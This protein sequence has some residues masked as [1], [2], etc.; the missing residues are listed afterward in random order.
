MRFP[1]KL[2]PSFE[3]QDR[4][5]WGQFFVFALT[6]LILSTT[7]P[8]IFTD[9]IN[10][11]PYRQG[12][13]ASHTVRA[14]RELLIEDTLGTERRR[15]DARQQA[16]RVFSRSTRESVAHQ[17]ETVFSALGGFS[18]EES[19]S[20]KRVYQERTT[21]ERRFNLDLVGEEWNVILTRSNWAPLESAVTEIA[22]P[23]LA[24]GI[25]A[26]KRPLRSMLTN[27]H[28]V[29][30][31]DAT[32]GSE[33]EINSTSELYDL[34][35][36]TDVA[37]ASFPAKGFRRGAAFDNVVRKLVESLLRPNV[38]YDVTETERRS[39]L[40]A[41]AVEP[42]YYRIKRGEVI[43]RA[44]DVISAS[45]ERRIQLLREEMQTS[46]DAWRHWAGYLILSS[47]ILLALHSFA[48]QCWPHYRPPL[49]DLVLLSVTLI[50][51]FLVMKLFWVLATSLSA[52]FYFFDPST[53]ILATPLAAGGILLQVTLGARGTFL[54]TLSFALL[55][56]VFLENSWL[57]LVLIVVGNIV[58]AL[59]VTTCTRRSAFIWAGARVAAVN[60]IIVLCFLL[61]FSD[62]SAAEKANRVLWA[63]VGGAFSGI[64]G[65]GLTPLAEHFGRYITDIKLLELASLDHPLLREL[66]VQAPGTWNHSMV[67]G[68]MAEA[69]AEA[70][71]ANPLL[72]RVGAYYHDVGKAKKP[73][74][75]V[76]NQT[77]ENRHD[78]LTPS[79]S[80][81]IIRT[82][83]KDGVEMAE[84]HGLPRPIIDFIPQH[85]GT[86]L[87]EYFYDKALSEA[88]EGEDVDESHYRYPGPK[89][90]T[91]EAGIL[92]LAD[93]VEASSRTLVDPSPA[94]I[95]GLVQKMINKVFTGGELD[96]SS[97]TLKDLH[98]IAKSFTRVL[99]GI[100]HRRIEYSEP[101]EKRRE[102]KGGGKTKN[103]APA[104]EATERAGQ[105]KHASRIVGEGEGEKRSGEGA[106]KK[107]DPTDSKETLKRL[108]I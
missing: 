16:K 47:T 64:L 93:G 107:Q 105:K 63:I 75:F 53:Y 43:V 18:A 48:L 106:A 9:L 49:R 27:G 86:A 78:K 74:Y 57:V 8:S 81:L 102:G 80:A 103:G 100:Y 35:E 66:S 82:H 46:D 68:Q 104:A 14:P 10:P 20:D 34:Q 56:G 26:N 52:M 11:V 67:M 42:V 21:F 91:R 17:L 79:M 37:A 61:L 25:V 2:V 77:R 4:T 108:G 94:K 98:L 62:F 7:L 95:Q 12:E 41:E 83:V 29:V 72:A 71:G 97:L 13:V 76:E 60:A 39:E 22:E 31:V 87:I 65:A 96:E 44:G 89:P 92:M 90:Q 15:T 36:V 84:K 19:D 85:H 24:R 101:A 58:G 45:Q 23:L 70:I 40:L 54:Y 28:S 1:R 69:A 32:D 99:T 55:T 6:V 3:L 51:S 30:L 88:P 5:G 38:T 73:A 59:A 50:F 33:R